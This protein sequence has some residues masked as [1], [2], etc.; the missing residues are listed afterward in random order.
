MSQLFGIIVERASFDEIIHAEEDN[1]ANTPAHKNIAAQHSGL[2]LSTGLS[3]Q[4][5]ASAAVNDFDQEIYNEM[6]PDQ[7]ILVAISN[8]EKLRRKL[9]KIIEIFKLKSFPGID[10]VFSESRD[11]IKATSENLMNNYIESALG[12][13]LTAIEPRLF[14]AQFDFDLEEDEY[15][16]ELYDEIFPRPWVNML[17]LDF[18]RI[19]SEISLYCPS[20]SKELLTDC[21]FKIYEEFLRIIKTLPNKKLSHRS[22]I[23]VIFDLIAIQAATNKFRPTSKVERAV[24]EIF[25][26]IK[27]KTIC[28]KN[29][30]AEMRE[31]VENFVKEAWIDGEVQ[32]LISESF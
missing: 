32:F 10:Q 31:N 7:S 30:V 13:L 28:E 15:Y 23:Q 25:N 29:I 8:L 4:A 14:S 3:G 21:L 16:D 5:T 22:A 1:E 12:S 6:T 20:R 2:S 19:N 18:M 27:D 24:K 26:T 9:P 11:N 17:L